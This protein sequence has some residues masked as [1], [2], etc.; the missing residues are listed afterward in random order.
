MEGCDYVNS[1]KNQRF[2]TKLKNLAIQHMKKIFF[3][4]VLPNEEKILQVNFG[5][6]FNARYGDETY[7]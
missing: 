4:F 5:L 3:F 2:R 6:R 7:K 1:L